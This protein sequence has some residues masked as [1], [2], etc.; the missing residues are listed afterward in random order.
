M[1]GE[2]GERV[3]GIWAGE[4][5]RGRGGGGRGMFPDLIIKF[6][7]GVRMLRHRYLEPCRFLP[8]D[9]HTLSTSSDS[10]IREAW[11]R[12]DK[13]QHMFTSLVWSAVFSTICMHW[14]PGWLESVTVRSSMAEAI[15]SG[16]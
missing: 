5:G 10:Q 1:E 11:F 15:G 3:K 7:S 4:G 8:A 13:G 9:I 12:N 6:V 14:F 16:I 2:T